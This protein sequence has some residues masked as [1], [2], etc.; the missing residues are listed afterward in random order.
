MWAFFFG[1]AP[2][3]VYSFSVFLKSIAQEFHSGRAAVSLASTLHNLCSAAVNPFL[4]RLA[5][6]FGAR[7]VVLPALA[8]VGL[9]LVSAKWIGSGIW[10]FY[11][12]FIALGVFGSPRSRSPTARPSRVGLTA[13]EGSL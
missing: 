1:E 4:G 3:V 8:G 11:L 9:T 2:V 12:F 5:D 6:R 10:Q 7:R 13:T